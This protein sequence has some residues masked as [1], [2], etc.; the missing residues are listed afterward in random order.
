MAAGLENQPRRVPVNSA[1]YAQDSWSSYEA[2]TGIGGI[3]MTIS[4]VLFF[5]IIVA[6]LRSRRPATEQEAAFETSDTIHGSDRSPAV[7]DRLGLWFLVAV[8]LVAAAYVP[9]LLTQGVNLD[10][11]GWVLF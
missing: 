9:A 5:F 2:L 11:P 4:A 3:V 7:L 6:T 10:S 1:P 8:A